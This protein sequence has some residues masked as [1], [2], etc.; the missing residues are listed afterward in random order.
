MGM[1]GWAIWVT[2]GI[3]SWRC[4]IPSIHPF[5]LSASSLS[6]TSLFSLL[7]CYKVFCKEVCNGGVACSLLKLGSLEKTVIASLF[8]SGLHPGNIVEKKVI[9][10][11]KE[12]QFMPFFDKKKTKKNMMPNWF[13]WSFATFFVPTIFWSGAK[14]R[15][16]FRESMSVLDQNGRIQALGFLSW[17]CPLQVTQPIT[18]F[19]SIA[20]YLHIHEI[21]TDVFLKHFH[22]VKSSSQTSQLNGF[23]PSWIVMHSQ[24]N[25]CRILLLKVWWSQM[26]FGVHLSMS[27]LK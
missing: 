25:E 15:F 2:S 16:C 6:M 4:D 27:C 26:I 9:C 21:R 11:S 13:F 12:P 7:N 23:F 24:H 14:Q 20:S 17:L 1:N 3:A 19:L 18:T 22:F 5:F 10:Y 8:H